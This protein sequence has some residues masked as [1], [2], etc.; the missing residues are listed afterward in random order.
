MNLVCVIYHNLIIRHSGDDV[1]CIKANK[2][3][4]LHRHIP[5][6]KQQ[7]KAKEV[8]SN[9]FSK[10]NLKLFV[11]DSKNNELTTTTS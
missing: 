8:S 2:H 1:Y 3:K 7:Q 5:T 10:K 9:L 4:Q 11:N 6:L